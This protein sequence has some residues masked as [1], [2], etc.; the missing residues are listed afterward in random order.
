MSLMQEE[1]VP[2][3]SHACSLINESGPGDGEHGHRSKLL[4]G[5]ELT[6]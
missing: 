2:L 4:R 6:Q 1:V 5:V 3:D